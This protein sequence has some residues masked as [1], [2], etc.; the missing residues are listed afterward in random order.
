ME[1]TVTRVQ[2]IKL[3]TKADRTAKTRWKIH[4]FELVVGIS[5][6]FDQPVAK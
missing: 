1:L 3:N 6:G 5:K 4:V 2:I